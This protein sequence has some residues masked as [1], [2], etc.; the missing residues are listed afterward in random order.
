MTS[1]CRGG[2]NHPNRPPQPLTWLRKSLKSNFSSIRRSMVFWASSS[3]WVGPI[4][5]IG[6]VG[7][8]GAVGM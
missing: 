3:C 4:G 2:S 8:G 5:P 1:I 6:S 7:C